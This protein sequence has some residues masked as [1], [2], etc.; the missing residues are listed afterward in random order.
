MMG[1]TI[2]YFYHYHSSFFRGFVKYRK[3][4][5]VLMFIS[6]IVN[7]YFVI[8]STNYYAR[9]GLSLFSIG[10]S[11]LLVECLLAPPIL[12]PNRFILIFSELGKC[13]YSIYLW[14]FTATF[15]VLNLLKYWGGQ[16]DGF[17]L[18]LLKLGVPFVFGWAMAHL[19]EFPILKLRDRIS[20]VDGAP[21]SL[22]P[23]IENPQV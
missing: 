20:R 8:K 7:S 21:L 13:S 4:F 12:N 3:F 11:A 19:V 9:F 1:V 15:Y 18:L 10:F 14:H 22:Y 16:P 2:S 5:F 17:S 6:F 23:V